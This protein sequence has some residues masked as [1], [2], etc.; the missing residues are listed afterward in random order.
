MLTPGTCLW[1]SGVVQCMQTSGSPGIEG[2]AGKQSAWR[3]PGSD[4]VW[5]RARTKVH[6]DQEVAVTAL[7]TWVWR[8]LMQSRHRF[9]WIGGGGCDCLGHLP[10]AVWCTSVTGN[11]L[12]QVN[13]WSGKLLQVDN[14][15]ETADVR[16][17]YLMQP[18]FSG[19]SFPLDIFR[20]MLEGELTQV[21]QVGAA[22][23][24]GHC[25]GHGMQTARYSTARYSTAS[26]EQPVYN[27]AIHRRQAASVVSLCIYINGKMALHAWAQMRKYTN[28]RAISLLVAVGTKA[29]CWTNTNTIYWAEYKLVLINLPG[30]EYAICILY[31]TC[32]GQSKLIPIG[33]IL[34]KWW[35]LWL[36]C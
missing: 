34:Q 7:V 14:I 21:A 26:T 13:I 4:A 1:R 5:F 16:E 6:L 25:L 27:F 15:S 12:V 11:C 3:S 24:P 31:P 10:D 33:P 29:R 30:S 35:S 22:L 20:A 8:S 9:T 23:P 32:G 19:D 36:T 18:M 28:T 2:N 17:T